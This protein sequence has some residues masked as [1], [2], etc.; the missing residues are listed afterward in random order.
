MTTTYD[1]DGLLSPHNQT[2]PSLPRIG[3]FVR[4]ALREAQE[5]TVLLELIADARIAMP[6]AVGRRAGLDTMG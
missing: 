4:A 3:V 5:A 1:P 6:A 2:P